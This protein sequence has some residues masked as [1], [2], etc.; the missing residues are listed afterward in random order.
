MLF[1]TS[2]IM[3]KNTLISAS[4]FI[5][6]VPFTTSGLTK[7]DEFEPKAAWQ[8][9]GYVFAIVWPLLYTLLFSMNWNILQVST[10]LTSSFKSIIARDTLIESSLQGLWLWTFRYKPE[11]SGRTP[12]QYFTGFASMLSL[13]GFSMYRLVRFWRN[14]MSWKYVWMYIPY[15]I[16]ISFASILNMQLLLGIVKIE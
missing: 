15:A 14:P 11:I 4:P 9:P 8:P 10:T 13:V 7:F 1:P 3:L 5:V 16:W 12:S 2:S 6:S